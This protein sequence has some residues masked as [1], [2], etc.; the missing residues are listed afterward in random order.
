MVKYALL[1]VITLGL[2]SNC[3]QGEPEPTQISVDSTMI[4][5]GNL[6][7]FDDL[8]TGS[9]AID[10]IGDGIVSWTVEGF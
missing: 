4:N 9:L 2:L 8:K 7:T 5:L 6:Q 3:K 1:L 10:K